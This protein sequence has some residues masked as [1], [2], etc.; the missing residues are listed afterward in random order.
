MDQHIGDII[1]SASQ[2]LFALRLLKHNGLP[3]N[4]LIQVYQATTLAKLLYASQAWWGFT[5]CSQRQRLDSFVNKSKRLGYCCHYLPNFSDLCEK[6][7][8]T[9]FDA[10]VAN[11]NHVLHQLL[12][13]KK[14]TPYNLRLRSH[15]F[16]HP[17]KDDRNFLSRMLYTNIY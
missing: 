12:P 11:P 10:I 2:S 3:E 9:L 13:Q 5:N 14:E 15:T 7:D 16:L 17:E 8:K 1:S 6:A 4:K